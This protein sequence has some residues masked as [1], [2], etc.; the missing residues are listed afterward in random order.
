MINKVFKNLNLLSTT[1]IK[2]A[3]K[4]YV[5]KDGRIVEN[6]TFKELSDNEFFKI[7]SE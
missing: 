1:E 3:D 2:I 6:G 5:L 7:M 4:I